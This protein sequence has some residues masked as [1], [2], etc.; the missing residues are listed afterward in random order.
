MSKNPDI[1][2]GLY[3]KKSTGNE[4]RRFEVEGS[5]RCG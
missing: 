3:K 5:E 1:S 2:G 4:K